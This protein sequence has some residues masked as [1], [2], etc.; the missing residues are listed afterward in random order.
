MKNRFLIIAL[1]ALSSLPNLTQA[2]DAPAVPADVPVAQAPAATGAAPASPAAPSMSG[3]SAF[4]PMLAIFGIFYFL[5]IMPQNKRMKE[6]KK[7][8]SE[9]A[10]GDD[11]LLNSGLLG[12]VVGV[13]E[14]VFTVE[15][16]AGARAKVVKNAVIRKGKNLHEEAAK[17]A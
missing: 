17:I 1:F 13:A 14:H 11:V 5:I 15:F 16:E 3:L 8:Q 4:L 2:Q 10:V 12:K 6:Q 7:M 9:I